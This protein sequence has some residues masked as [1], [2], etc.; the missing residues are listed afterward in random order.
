MLL[1]GRR[2]SRL[3][4]FYQPPL[5]EKTQ[6]ITERVMH[7]LQAPGFAISEVITKDLQPAPAVCLIAN[8]D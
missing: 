6:H 8:G 2:C 4:C 5:A 1:P 7:N 3:Y